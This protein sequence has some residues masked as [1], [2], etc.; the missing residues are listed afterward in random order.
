MDIRENKKLTWKSYFI[1]ILITKYEFLC[2]DT[3]SCL[4]DIN[5]P[6]RYG[7]YPKIELLRFLIHHTNR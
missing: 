3:P 2:F 6:M 1:C 7:I 4:S 5:S